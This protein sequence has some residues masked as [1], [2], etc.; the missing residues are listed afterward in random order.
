MLGIF[1]KHFLGILLLPYYK[2][3]NIVTGLTGPVSKELADKQVHVP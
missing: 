1:F 3:S 2:L